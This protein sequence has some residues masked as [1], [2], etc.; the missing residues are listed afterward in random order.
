MFV[1]WR[2]A[3]AAGAIIRVSDG[4]TPASALA[5]MYTRRLRLIQRRG[6][7]EIGFAEA[8]RALHAC[9]EAGARV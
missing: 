7:P 2:R 1:A 3:V 4:G 5:A 6:T 9:G 8:V